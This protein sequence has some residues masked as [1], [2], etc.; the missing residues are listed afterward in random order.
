[1][2]I[3]KPMQRPMAVIAICAFLAAC[4][5]SPKGLGGETSNENPCAVGMSSLAG[6][7]AGAAL[8]A[9]LGGK[10]G[11]LKGG[12]AGAALGAVA[13]AGINLRSKQTKTAAQSEQEFLR[14]NPSLP[15]QPMVTSYAAQINTPSAQRGQ[16]ILVNSEL[17]LINGSSEKVN[18]V[19]E[20]LVVLDPKGEPFKSGGKPFMATSAGRF[21]NSFELTLPQNAPQGAYSLKTNV[22]V[23]GAQVA[24]RNLH[25]QVV[26]DGGAAVVVASR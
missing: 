3:L 19:R 21:E 26:W 2:T 20:E 22:F 9:V 5:S 16:P 15:A 10:D 23:N 8:G 4:A 7:A 25:T 13:C 18:E 11:A 24:S 12:V 1:M 6:A 14:T 17:E